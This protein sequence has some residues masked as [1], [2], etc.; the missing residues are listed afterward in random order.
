[1]VRTLPPSRRIVGFLALFLLF[2]PVNAPAGNAS[3]IG[4]VSSEGLAFARYLTSV[5]ERDP[6]K[7]SGPVAV[8]IEA[9]LPGLYKQ[10]RLLAIRKTGDSERSEF[11][12][13]KIEGD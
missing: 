6:F 13:I 1:M 5:Y 11:M 8:E 4:P 2:I 10:T 12:V 7:E 9:S 3:I